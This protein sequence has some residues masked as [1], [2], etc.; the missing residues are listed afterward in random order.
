[1]TDDCGGHPMKTTN[2][3]SGRARAHVKWREWQNDFVPTAATAAVAGQRHANKK[4]QPLH[5][6]IVGLRYPAL[7]FGG[8]TGAK[9]PDVIWSFIWVSGSAQMWAGVGG[10]GLVFTR[11]YT[12]GH[13]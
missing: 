9:W 11:T 10:G 6:D 3:Q 1:M 12:G 13:W 4:N 2:P 8:A 7:G 5:R